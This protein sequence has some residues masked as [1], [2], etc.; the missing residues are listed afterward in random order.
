MI[1][2]LFLIVSFIFL[3]SSASNTEPN[4]L[5]EKLEILD[6]QVKLENFS[7]NLYKSLG[8]ENLR[9]NYPAFRAAIEGFFKLKTSN[10]LG[11]NLLTI[12]DFS[13]SSTKE[14]L[15]VINL[16]EQKII[17][18]TLVAHGQESGNLYA[19][20]FS[21]IPSSHQS[22]LGFYITDKVYT[23]K[24][25]ISLRLDGVEKG[26]NDKA[27]ERAI[28]M[29]SAD[30]VSYDFIEKHGRLGRSFGCPA[31]PIEKHEKI[32]RL[33]AGRSCL[34]IYHTAPDYHAKSRMKGDEEIISGLMSFI[35]E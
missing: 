35:K 24:H 25:G 18:R 2:R 30:Y 5:D 11:S 19:N 23:G 16:I 8:E 22:S 10:Q 12:I 7:K 28:V 3:F 21:N 9:P 31:I 34:Y 4:R 17:Y 20:K 33:L 32:I 15:W 29:H 27:R 14:R 1:L 13:L 6:D 26:I